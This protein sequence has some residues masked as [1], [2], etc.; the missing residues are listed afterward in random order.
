MKLILSSQMLDKTEVAR[1]LGDAWV[2]ISLVMPHINERSFDG[3]TLK[4]SRLQ[5][6]SLCKLIAETLVLTFLSFKH[7]MYIRNIGGSSWLS[8]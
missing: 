8:I 1:R 4:G 3:A 7:N 6:V 2:K 5:N